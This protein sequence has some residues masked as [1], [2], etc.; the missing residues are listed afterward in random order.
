MVCSYQYV[1]PCAENYKC[2]LKFIL[3]KLG[4]IVVT[5]LIWLIVGF[6]IQ[7]SIETRN[8]T[9]VD[10]LT[11]WDIIL[12]GRTLGSIWQ[13]FNFNL[14]LYL[15][16]KYPYKLQ[17]ESQEIGEFDKIQLNSRGFKICSNH[18]SFRIMGV[19]IISAKF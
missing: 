9:Y 4:R 5:I 17:K 15:F 2:K 7:Y 11:N 6:A 14:G 8:T 19:H 16:Y 3:F 1:D 18:M 13:I 10:A 12:I